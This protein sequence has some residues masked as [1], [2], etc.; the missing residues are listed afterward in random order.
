M[1]IRPDTG[2]S[3]QHNHYQDESPPHPPILSLLLYLLQTGDY[4]LA[5][6]LDARVVEHRDRTDINAFFSNMRERILY[7][8]WL[9]DI[10]LREDDKLRLARKDT[11]FELLQ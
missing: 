6:H 11:A 3:R 4:R 5:E 7:V 8:L 9:A 10:R 1:K 2:A